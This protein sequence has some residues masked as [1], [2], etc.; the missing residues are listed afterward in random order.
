[1]GL[2]INLTFQNSRYVSGNVVDVMLLER[3]AGGKLGDKIQKLAADTAE[4][5]S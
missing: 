4:H 5:S 3:G 2:F 1:M